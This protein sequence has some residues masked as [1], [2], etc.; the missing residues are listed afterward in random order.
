MENIDAATEHSARNFL[1]MGRWVPSRRQAQFGLA[2]A[3]VTGGTVLGWD[4]LVAAGVAPLILSVLPCVAMCALGLCAMRGGG[5][6][7]CRS[8]GAAKQNGSNEGPDQS[9]SREQA[10]EQM[11]PRKQL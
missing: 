6:Q 7:S 4:W 2:I 8:T 11:P 5:G 3:G 9:T 10:T 1:G